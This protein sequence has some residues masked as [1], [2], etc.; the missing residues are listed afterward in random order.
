MTSTCGAGLLQ[1][2]EHG[3]HGDYYG[4]YDYYDCYGYH[5]CYDFDHYDS[6]DG[7]ARSSDDDGR[8][9]SSDGG[10][11]LFATWAVVG[12]GGGTGRGTR[13]GGC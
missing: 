2:Y 3:G 8:A 12:R 13:D 5:D 4:H 11:E 9:Q 10:L 7:R 6:D 1:D